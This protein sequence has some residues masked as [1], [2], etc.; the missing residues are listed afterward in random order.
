MLLCLSIY[1]NSYQKNIRSIIHRVPRIAIEPVKIIGS[2][3]GYCNFPKAW[4]PWPGYFS[5]HLLKI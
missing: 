2:F 3:V 4:F 1:T 5:W